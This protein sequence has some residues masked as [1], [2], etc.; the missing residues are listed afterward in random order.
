MADQVAKALREF[1]DLLWKERGYNTSTLGWRII[2]PSQ[3]PFQEN[4][5]DCGVFVCAYARCRSIRPFN[6]FDFKAEDI[7]RIR[8]EMKTIL[9]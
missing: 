2:Q 8:Q 4:G 6:V 5:I 9:S 1:F 3:R 7:P